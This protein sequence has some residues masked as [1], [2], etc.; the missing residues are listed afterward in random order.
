MS[1][2][3]T[4]PGAA[5]GSR[6]RRWILLG[7]PLLVVLAIVLWWFTGPGKPGSSRLSRFSP[8]AAELEGVRGVFLYYGTPGSDSVVA[9]YRD[10][11]V[12]D[13]PVD[14]VRAI[15]RELIAGPTGS[16]VTAFPDGAELLNTYWTV[17]GTLYLD[18]NRTL[19]SGFRGGSGKE[20]Q[21]LASIVR[22]AADNLPQVHRVAILVEGSPVETIGGHYD[23]LQPLDVADWR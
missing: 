9:E 11:V 14:Q 4:S 21:L 12:K 1:A 23:T 10:V 22:T 13:H 7:V 20:R 18:W 5:P 8:V 2:I 16:R 17:R 15:Y 6:R 19:I 3:R